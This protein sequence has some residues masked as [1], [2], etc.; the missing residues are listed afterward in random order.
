MISVGPRK[1]HLLAIHRVSC[2]FLDLHI[3]KGAWNE[4]QNVRGDSGSVQTWQREVSLQTD[5]LLRR[6]YQAD[7]LNIWSLPSSEITLLE[8]DKAKKLSGTD[9]INGNLYFIRGILFPIS[10][11]DESSCNSFIFWFNLCLFPLEYY[12][13]CISIYI[14]MCI[15]TATLTFFICRKLSF[16]FPLEC[17]FLVF[18]VSIQCVVFPLWLLSHIFSDAGIVLCTHRPLFISLSYTFIEFGMF[19]FSLSY[20]INRFLQGG[21][22]ISTNGKMCNTI[23]LRL[24]NSY[25]FLSHSENAGAEIELKTSSLLPDQI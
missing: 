18:V 9:I 5:P 7:S 22:L 20:F 11:L 14:C 17:L 3:Q 10:K 16:E 21:S 8:L 19:N 24:Q 4:E 23:F 15:R 13:L 12:F 25:L 6:E 2:H 1:L